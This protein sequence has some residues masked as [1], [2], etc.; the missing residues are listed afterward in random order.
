M[1]KIYV[2]SSISVFAI[3]VFL[4]GSFLKTPRTL[5]TRHVVQGEEA[6]EAIGRAEWE[7][8]RLADPATGKIPAG[9]REKEL[10]FAAGMPRMAMS[11]ATARMTSSFA[12]R[13]PV[14]MG[15]RTR[16]LAIDVTDDNVIFAGSVNG[17]LYKSINGGQNWT[18]V[19]PITTNPAVTWVAQ[20]TRPGHTNTWYY[21]TG[22]GVG[23]SGSGANAYYLGN[24]MWKSTDGGS[25]WTSLTFTSSNTPAV[26]D[27]I[28]DITYKV[29]TD[30]S[31]SVNSVLYAATYGAIYRSANGG[32]A[33]TKMLGS[34]SAYSYYTDVD[35][36]TTGIAY[37]YLSSDGGQKGVFRRDPSTGWANIN[38]PGWDTGS[39]N[40][41]VIGINPSNENEVYFLG[42][43]PNMGK[44][45]TNY[46]GDIE[47]SSLW[48]YTYVSGNG[49]GVGGVWTDLSVNIPFTGTEMG[50]FNSQ[51]GYDLI[52]RVHPAHQNVVYIGGTNLFRSD[53]AFTTS[54]MIS[55]I[56]GYDS[57]S[58]IPFYTNYPNHHSDEHNIAFLH[59]TP[60]VMIQSNDGGIYKTNDD[61]AY[62][63]V[64]QDLN[65]GY[66]TSQF[67]AVALDHGGSNDIIIGGTQDN[68]TWFTNSSNA[69]VAWTH[70]GF[71]DG[72]FC[73]IDN[74][75]SNYYMTRQEGKLSRNLLDA[76][77]NLL[78]FGRID[79]IDSVDYIF[80]NPFVLDPNNND[81]MYWIAGNHIWRNDSLTTLPTAGGWDSISTG[82][83]RMP[84]TALVA[85]T[86]VT[87][88]GIS[89][90][91][92]N[93]LYWGTNKRALFRTD[94]ANTFAP[95]TTT[96]TS[97]LF[98]AS[99]YINCIAV[100]PNNA[101]NLLVV[102]SNYSIYSLF[103]SSDGGTTFTKVGGNLEANS[104][105]TGNGPSLRWASIVPTINGNV[106]LVA[107]STGLYGTNAL[108][109]LTTV[110]TELAPNEIGN[111]VCDQIDVRP[112][113]GTVIVGTHGGGVFSSV[114]ND[115][116]ATGVPTISLNE[117]I[118]IYPNPA[119]EKVT[120][121]FNK[122]KGTTAKIK[123]YDATGRLITQKDYD[124]STNGIQ[125]FTLNVSSFD[126][127]T[128]FMAI[129]DGERVVVRKVVISK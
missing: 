65:N 31:D 92:A 13:G 115:T 19:S 108:T 75:H 110:W 46:R 63:V 27:N 1:K 49:T 12:Y 123:V 66:N 99:G 96:I 122:S 52:V 9:M 67:Y 126:N 25:T 60:D 119:T 37:A 26:F 7:M 38:P 111:L 106:Y 47:W 30:P 64:W 39:Y 117:S 88:L 54:T 50:N 3:A 112:I 84:D 22:E 40:R 94:N 114:I 2:L 29:A 41:V 87:A 102:F 93:R 103:Y 101:D 85:G 28:W 33:W 48:K 113:D 129:I 125:S 104:T 76:N 10:A 34:T 81:I 51:G 24:G 44:T 14:N 8:S 73:A 80:I 97:T 4:F 59:N 105:G 74:G 91:P 118:S 5:Q 79:P 78:S 62:P 58:T 43:T 120:A 124:R 32:S 77:G 90:T 53:D 45:T 6:E 86:Y 116:L 71:G 98:T 55:H 95:T 69:S 16:A 17:G 57:L 15:G 107:A 127:G 11:Q 72:G 42:E 18:R 89:T 100:D 68:G 83:F 56:G 109:G 36:T 61:R 35:V 20:D 121:E 21:T 23:A 128:Y 70:P 82:W